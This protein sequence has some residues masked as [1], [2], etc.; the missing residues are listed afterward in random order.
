MTIICGAR[1]KKDGSPCRKSALIN[2]AGERCKWH[3]GA[4]HSGGPTHH[5]YKHGRRSKAYIENARRARTE[6]R[7]LKLLCIKYGLFEG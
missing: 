7:Y 2:G 3:G 1:T 6:L 4:S 5:L